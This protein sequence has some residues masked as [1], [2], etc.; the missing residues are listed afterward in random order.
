MRENIRNNKTSNTKYKRGLV[1]VAIVIGALLI[2]GAQ[3]GIIHVRPSDAVPLNNVADI[4][5]LNPSEKNIIGINNNLI[6]KATED[7]ITYYN[8][9]GEEL[10]NDAY[11]IGAI[12]VKQRTPYVGVCGN[13]GKQLV[14]YDEK[15]RVVD[16]KTTKPIVYFSISEAGGSVIIQQESNAYII[17][18]YDKYGEILCQRTSFIS[19]SGYPLTAELSPDNSTL[20]ISCVSS[21]EPKV[22]SNILA[23]D[24]TDKRTDKVDGLTY[25]YSVENNL[26]YKIEFIN[27][28]TYV[29]VGDKGLSWY[30]L[31][32]DQVAK[33]EEMSVMYIPYL[34]KM[35]KYGSGYFPVI[36][37][38]TPSKNIV[39]RQDS[40]IY[41]NEK[42]EKFH[43][44]NFREGVTDIYSDE[45]G[46]IIKADN[47]FIG[48]DKL[49]NRAFEYQGDGVVQMIY[50]PDL[51]KGIAVTKDN[52]YLVKPKTLE[53][54]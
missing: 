2:I 41:Y 17:T 50:K 48:V 34:N 10:W 9:T 46:V 20:L 36:T 31:K 16:I 49:G 51:K 13:Q 19:D 22:T 37:A 47:Q 12:D 43:E 1:I 38:Q 18:A 45:N 52:V 4:I 40:L 28:D 42:G 6:Y 23:I 7:G 33:S 32:G 8:M 5:T 11:S 30:N 26:V 53:S 54:K 39:H 25:G 21:N 27:K 44:Y 29:L 35:S 3:Q 24:V 15:E 14:V